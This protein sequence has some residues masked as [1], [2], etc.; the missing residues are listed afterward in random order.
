MTYKLRVWCFWEAGEIPARPR[1]C[2]CRGFEQFATGDRLWEG[3]SHL[4]THESGDRP[5][6]R[7]SSVDFEGRVDGRLDVVR[8]RF[9]FPLCT[10]IDRARRRVCLPTISV[11]S[12]ST[13]DPTAALVL[14]RRRW[15]ALS[16]DG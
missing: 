1:H 4:L 12:R 14:L 7:M 11:V 9:P 3:S 6:A 10:T 2:E 5:D 13:G 16:L 15:A 8:F